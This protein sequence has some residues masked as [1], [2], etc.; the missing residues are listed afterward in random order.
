MKRWYLFGFISAVLMSCT[1]SETR[2]VTNKKGKYTINMPPEW[3]YSL[4]D[5]STR[6]YRTRYYGTNY[7]TGTLFVS[8]TDSDY[9]SLEE[10]VIN[11]VGQLKHGFTDYKKIGDGLTQINGVTT[12]WHRMKDTDKGTRFVTL[13]YLMQ[14]KGRK[15]FVIN[16]S[17]TE[18]TFDDFEDDFNKI[19]FS[20]KIL[21]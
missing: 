21:D 16:C 3:D 18:G 4:E 7:V 10:S 11:Y 12:S 15:L 2:I 1:S 8:M 20:F 19:A 9:E 5:L 13:Q 14:P 6:L 17:A